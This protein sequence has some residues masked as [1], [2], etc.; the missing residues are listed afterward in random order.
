MRRQINVADG[1]VEHDLYHDDFVCGETCDDTIE[2]VH[3]D[4]GDV[5]SCI[6]QKLLLTPRQSLPNQRHSIFRT[7][8]TINNKVCNVIV[9][10]GSSDN[11]V[12][13]SLVRALGLSTEK[14]PTP[15]KIGWIKKGVDTSVQAICR[16]PFSIGKYYK[17]EVLCDVVDMD[18][19]HLLLGRP[20]QFD[21]AAT[22]NGKEN[23][24][25][26]TWEGKKI[27]LMSFIPQPT[28]P[29]VQPAKWSCLTVPGGALEASIHESKFVLA[30][31]LK[32]ANQADS[33]LSPLISDLLLEFA[34]LT[35]QELP[36]ELP[37]L[38][39]IQHCI[40]FIP[41]S[42]LPNQPHYRMSPKEHET[43]Q[44]MVDDLLAKQL[45][46]VSL[47]PCVVP[48]LLVPKKNG[49]WRM[50]VDSRTINKIT[51]KYRFPIPR[52]E[53]MLD[54]LEGSRIF[55]KLDL[56]SG[57][58][59]IR[60]RPGDEWKTAFKTREGLYEWLVMPFGICNAP[61]TFMRLMNDVLKP[62][63]GKFVVVYF[64]D[65]LIYSTTTDDHLTHLRAI[66]QTLSDNKL[67]LNLKKCNFLTNK[68]LFLGFII[69]DGGI[70]VDES[71][72]QAICDWPTP[73]NVHEVRS[74]HDLASFYRRF[75]CN[76]SS[77][78]APL[79]NCLKLGKFQW[80]PAQ[81]ESFS[82]IKARL[83]SVPIL[84]LPN[85]DK[86][87]VVE[88]D[89]SMLGIGA[90]LTQDGRPVEYFSEKLNDARQ[91]WSTYEQDFYAIVRA[92]KHWEYYLIQNE[93]IL[94]SDHHSL[95]FLNSQKNF[96]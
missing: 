44:A 58:H 57:Y 80:G 92:L 65:I 59:Q 85:F 22:H 88:T 81:D 52:L 8:C 27:A 78:I 89:A 37:P 82:A 4:E 86:V 64:D 70:A 11:I 49:S 31:L 20:W 95:Q 32:E 38:R 87:F 40:D 3:G 45:I 36:N 76:F 50:C 24:Y 13:A 26:F 15:Y 60:I 90:V 7:R 16:I 41:G 17:D 28:P 39:D 43:L 79:T 69:S 62:F 66:L 6:V 56:R 14:H 51:V 12:S 91:K 61:S 54:K 77:L 34:N 46:R 93:F 63:I 47:S 30:L 29:Q 19:C 96:S 10:S 67:Y 55:S 35:P 53:D 18:A 1:E 72:V 2:Q 9:D 74:F 83:S 84:A 68:L 5:I 71:K 75:V 94:H 25:V 42:S 23:S 48:A 73:T 33:P 21:V